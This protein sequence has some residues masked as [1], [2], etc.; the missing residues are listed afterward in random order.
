MIPL[1][2]VQ[3]DLLVPYDDFQ[4]A[5][6]TVSDIIA[7]RILPTAIEFME[8][9]SVLAVERLSQKEMPHDDAA[10]HLLI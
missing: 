5:A 6:G 2:K 1:P 9:D 3:V 7:H 10:A 8:R 4:A